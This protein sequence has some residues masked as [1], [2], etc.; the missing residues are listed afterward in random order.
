MA[1]REESW[2]SNPFSMSLTHQLSQLN[3]CCWYLLLIYNVYKYIY[4]NKH[5][6]KFTIDNTGWIIKDKTKLKK[7]KKIK[8]NSLF[9]VHTLHTL[10]LLLFK[11]KKTKKKQKSIIVACLLIFSHHKY[12]KIIYIVDRCTVCVLC[13]QDNLTTRL[14]IRF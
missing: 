14:V 4:I 8:S 7:K 1:D 10:L 2:C 11:N 5:I 12:K 13:I 6:Y 3:C 9:N